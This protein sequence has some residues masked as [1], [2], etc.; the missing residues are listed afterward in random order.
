MGSLAIGASPRH[1]V[2]DTA[3]RIEAVLAQDG[4]DSYRGEMVPLAY[5]IDA[6]MDALHATSP[7]AKGD[8]LLA[9]QRLRAD[10]KVITRPHYPS[11]LS[12]YKRA[13]SSPSQS[14]KGN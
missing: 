7:I 5:T 9:L 11:G 6:L 10:N 3:A 14:P 1:T 8:V 12:L 4:Y 13:A 2:Q